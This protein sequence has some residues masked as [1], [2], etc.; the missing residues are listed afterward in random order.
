MVAPLRVAIALVVFWSS[1]NLGEVAE[2]MSHENDDPENYNLVSVRVVTGLEGLASWFHQDWKLIYPDVPTAARAYIQTLPGSERTLLRQELE[3]F[4]EAN[5]GR[6][7]EQV[8]EAW[9]ALGVGSW[10]RGENTEAML[11]AV[12]ET[13]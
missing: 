6:T 9:I 10:P 3:S 5:S 1:L 7:A 11:T 13:L 8:R 2:A 12:L 4:L